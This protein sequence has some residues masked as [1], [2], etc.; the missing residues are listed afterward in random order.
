MAKIKYDVSDVEPGQDIDYDTPVPKGVYKAKVADITEGTSQS[1]GNDMLTVEYELV[2]GD[3]KGRKLWDYVVLTDAA[4]WKLRQFIDA[5]GVKA[6]GTLDTVE[7]IGNLV[8]VR[9]KHEADSRPETVENN[10]GK[11]VVRARV[12]SVN[13]IPEDEDEPDE[14]EE[15]DDEE[16]DEE[17][18]EAGTEEDLTYEDLEQYDRDELKALIKEEELGI[19]VTKAT[20]DE[21]LLEKVADALDLAPEEEDE[22][23]DDEEE[24]A[25]YTE[26]SLADLKTECKQRG[27]PVK[28][29][30]AKLAER[31]EADDAEEAQDGEEPF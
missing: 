31:L 26:W 30:R 11:P 28:G 5:M 1:S 29:T 23:E 3:F 12:G 15:D 17:D 10:G 8:L 25:D 4:A 19:R 16:E 18:D 21:K 14:D 7:L 27:L 22:E 24:V 6:K 9:V 20:T 2:E 13:P